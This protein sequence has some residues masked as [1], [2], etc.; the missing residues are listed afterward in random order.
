[1]TINVT[2]FKKHLGKYLSL[3]QTEDVLITRNGK[4]ISVLTDPFTERE[5]STKQQ[6]KLQTLDMMSKEEFNAM[7]EEGYKQALNG[8]A[9]E[10]DAAFDQ[11]QKEL[12]PKD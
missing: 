1:M 4:V 5:R 8:E 3:S 10:L 12:K 11:L 9:I 6:Q 7:L 2:E